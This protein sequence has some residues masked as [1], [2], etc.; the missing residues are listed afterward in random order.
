[1]KNF[2]FILLAAALAFAAACVEKGNIVPA[3]EAPVEEVKTTTLT[4]TVTDGE[5]LDTRTFLNYKD[6]NAF[7][8]WNS[9]D[10]IYVFDER[11][12]DINNKIYNR[13]VFTQVREGNKVTFK[14]D[15]WPVNEETGKA[16][17]PIYALFNRLGGP[18]DNPDKYNADWIKITYGGS[19]GD[20]IIASLRDEQYVGNFDSFAGNSN[21]AVGKIEGE[22][23]SYTVTLQNVCGLLKFKSLEKPVKVTLKGNNNEIIAGGKPCYGETVNNRIRVCF[24]ADGTPFW[25]TVSSDGSR[26]IT[27]TFGDIWDG[28]ENEYYICVLPPRVNN[29]DKN[30]DP[31]T[32]SGIFTKGITLTVETA[33]GV[34]YTKTGKKELKVVRNKVVDL[35]TLS[36]ADADQPEEGSLV[37]D[38]PM[39]ADALPEGFPT[40]YGDSKVGPDSYTFIINGKGYSFEF[41][42]DGR[43]ESKPNG[44]N[45][46]AET[47][48]NGYYFETK[49][50][51]GV[52]YHQYSLGSTYG[53]VKFPAV[54]NMRLESVSVYVANSPELSG[55]TSYNKVCTIREN[56]FTGK[57]NSPGGDAPTMTS[58]ID[59][60]DA[61]I[62]SKGSNK[63]EYTW[64]FGTWNGTT[65][66]KS[67]TSYYFQSRNG[68]VK[69]SKLTLTYVPAE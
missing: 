12:L 5:T 52:D 53:Y 11:D 31:L 34:T 43:T 20:N 26:E 69:L 40:K 46:N 55:E 68:S 6:G 61:V 54:E 2:R 38:L 16:Y 62:L 41:N 19:H 49:T 29:D 30:Y 24:N 58:D 17:K 65:G 33:D 37:I 22:E 14:C 10:Y 64:T 63:P 66:T 57:V 23:G 28:G 35:G 25:K 59:G 56:V 3:E 18:D 39:T 42:A 8:D 9:A 60:S 21:V 48:E 51:D 32:N 50:S 1:M 13:H 67:N 4:I 7:V 47:T 27:L 15:T 45:Q 36:V 44:V